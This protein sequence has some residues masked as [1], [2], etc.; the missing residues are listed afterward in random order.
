MNWEAV[1]AIGEIIGALVVVITLIYLALQV[2]Q[3][4]LSMRVAAKQ[5]M[6]RQYS[7]FVDLL[8]LNP[9]ML[10]LYGMAQSGT[11]MSEEEEFKYFLLMN[12]AAWYFAAMYFQYRAHNLSEDEWA[13]SKRV[14]ERYCAMPGFSH[15]WQDNREY[16]ASDFSKYVDELTPK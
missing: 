4:S 13:Q 11:P 3:N 7:D 6:T 8:L 15:Y 9:E 1:G 5:E 10:E 2:R 16:F 12:K 14:I